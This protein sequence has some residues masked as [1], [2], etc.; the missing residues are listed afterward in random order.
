MKRLVTLAALAALLF[1]ATRD[2]R[3]ADDTTRRFTLAQA[4]DAA[5]SDNPELA[6]SG[7]SV[8]IA[9]ARVDSAKALRLPRLSVEAGVQLWSEEVVIP[10]GMP[11]PGQPAMSITGREQVTGSVSVTLAQPLSGL[12]VIGR[13]IHIEETGV[14]L[15]KTELVGAKLDV[16]AQAAELYLRAMQARAAV[17]IAERSVTQLDAQAQRAKALEAGGVL[18]KVDVMRIDSARSQAAQQALG[19][20]DGVDQATDALAM[21]L[22]L[23]AGASIETIDDLPAALPPPPWDEAGAMKIAVAKRPELRSAR[24]RAQQAEG[25]VDVKRSDYFPNVI[26]LAN[27]QH[28]EGQGAFSQPDAFF[29]GVT[30]KWDLWDWG[31]RGADMREVRGRAAQA[32]LTA[33]RQGDRVALDV[34]GRLRSAGTTFKQLEVA[35]QGL[36]TAEEAYRIQSVRFQNGNATT[37]D[38][39][40]AEADVARARLAVSTYRYEYAIALVQLAHAIGESPLAALVATPHAAASGGGSR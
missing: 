23:P 13:L 36:T 39:L 14:A 32:K 3:A 9:G 6:I 34:R 16:A 35:A 30:L 11:V 10:F 2:G 20:R 4:V 18:G 31:K 28:T 22:G 19:A 26:A 21:L 33:D 29:V 38:V 25:A 12:A 24:L 7:R 17:E 40:D 1:G 27:Y 37:L 5:I 8:G 15:A